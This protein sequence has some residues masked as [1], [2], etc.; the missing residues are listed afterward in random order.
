MKKI[1]L[2]ILIFIFAIGQHSTLAGQSFT[3]K[4]K[5]FWTNFYRGN[6]VATSGIYHQMKIYIGGA[7]TGDSVKIAIAEGK[8]QQWVK[9]YW[10]PADSIV[11]SD[12]IPNQN[13]VGDGLY[14]NSAIHITSR[15]ANIVAYAHIYESATSAAAILLPVPVWGQ[16]HYVLSAKQYYSSSNYAA[17]HI[18]ANHDS[19]WVEISPS[20]PTLGG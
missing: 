4:G 19:T 2:A 6:G 11:A 18:V 8:P 16:E 14:A 9:T 13:I 15:T 5:D 17:F 7:S 12:T 20:Q 1:Y 3:N 10:V